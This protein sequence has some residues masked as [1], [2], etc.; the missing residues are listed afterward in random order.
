MEETKNNMCLEKMV[1][2]CVVVFTEIVST[3]FHLDAEV[4]GG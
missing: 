1:I 4:R 2:F 3:F